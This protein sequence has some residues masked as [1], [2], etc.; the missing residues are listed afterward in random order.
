MDSTKGA[1]RARFMVRKSGRKIL[2]Y[3]IFDFIYLCTY[4]LT[5]RPNLEN[6]VFMFSLSSF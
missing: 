6:N 1:F 2:F 4:F 5:D 3:F